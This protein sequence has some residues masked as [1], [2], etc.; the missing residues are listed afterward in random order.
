MFSIEINVRTC[1][2]KAQIGSIKMRT[3]W[4]MLPGDKDENQMCP[5]IQEL[6]QSVLDKVH[7][8]Q[9]LEAAICSMDTGFDSA[10]LKLQQYVAADDG[11]G[12]AAPNLCEEIDQVKYDEL[13][14][15]H[16]EKID[17]YVGEDGF[18]IRYMLRY[19]CEPGR[20]REK[21]YT[22]FCQVKTPLFARISRRQERKNR[23]GIMSRLFAS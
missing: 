13:V 8:G 22:G 1:T 17:I 12:H 15:N 5:L 10:I 20:N 7:E 19:G 18:Q 16:K 14:K 2:I 6:V 23:N 3:T 9:T 11:A 4:A 21:C